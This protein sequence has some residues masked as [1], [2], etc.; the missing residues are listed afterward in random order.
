MEIHVNRMSVSEKIVPVSSFR[1]STIGLNRSQSTKE[2]AVSPEFYQRRGREK[3]DCSVESILDVEQ[4]SSLHKPI[5]QNDPISKFISRG[6]FKLNS[7]SILSKNNS[8][9]HINYEKV[10]PNV[11]VATNSS[12]KSDSINDTDDDG[13]CLADKILPNKSQLPIRRSRSEAYDS[14]ISV[15]QDNSD[16]LSVH[17]QQEEKFQSIIS[18]SGISFSNTLFHHPMES[19]QKINSDNG[20]NYEDNKKKF[21]HGTTYSFNRNESSSTNTQNDESSQDNNNSNNNSNNYRRKSTETA[22]LF[23][24]NR[25]Y[26]T[27]SMITISSDKSLIKDFSFN[28]TRL[29][30]NKTEYIDLNAI[31]DIRHFDDGSNSRIFE[32]K[33]KKDNVILKMLKEHPPDVVNAA[34]ELQLEHEVLVRVSHPNIVNYFG[35]GHVR[36]GRICL[37]MERLSS[38]T[39]KTLSESKFKRKSGSPFSCRKIIQIGQQLADAIYYLHEEFHPYAMI[40]HRDL[41]P[42]NIGFTES[43]ILKL[44]DF[45]LCSVVH[46]KIEL[47]Q[48]YDMTG[49]TGSLRYMAPEV[50]LARPYNEKVDIYSYGII[51]WEIATGQTAFEG[52]KCSQLAHTVAIKCQRPPVS[53]DGIHIPIHLAKVIKSCWDGNFERRPSAYDLLVYMTNFM[54]LC[55]IKQSL[56]CSSLPLT[57]SNETSIRSLF[58]D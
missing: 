12:L 22:D 48:T 36:D 32:G 6:S 40:V 9:R 4:D 28:L 18:P 34:R 42:A 30:T 47:N 2:S 21:L 23:L 37:V 55:P 51:M 7:F 44:I 46:K 31:L 43:G 24:L 33:F 19:N 38:S 50:I 58:F 57:W 8:S 41:K 49:A 15:V 11:I 56:W 27:Q 52:M 5:N 53:G 13:R 1:S 26:S 10:N 29:S 35:C 45:G 39:L 14:F 20:N 25:Q 3:D 54:K 16:V 17:N